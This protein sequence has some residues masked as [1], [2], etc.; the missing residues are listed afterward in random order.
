MTTQ[1]AMRNRKK[2]LADA[3]REAEL[4]KERA[5]ELA[6]QLKDLEQGRG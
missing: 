3:Q 6:R 2:Q 4:A 1:K 5:K